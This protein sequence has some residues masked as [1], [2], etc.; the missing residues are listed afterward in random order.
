MNIETKDVLPNANVYSCCDAERLPELERPPSVDAHELDINLEEFFSYGDWLADGL[1]SDQ[2]RRLSKA[3]ITAL[4][5]ASFRPYL[6]V[7]NSTRTTISTISLHRALL[8][9]I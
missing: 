7:R 3:E 1:L 5:V 6:V 2:G 8:Y 4:L 9:D